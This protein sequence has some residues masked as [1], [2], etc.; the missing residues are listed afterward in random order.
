MELFSLFQFN[1]AQLMEAFL[2]RSDVDLHDDLAAD[3]SPLAAP[4]TP[5]PPPPSLRVLFQSL[6]TAMHHLRQCCANAALTIQLFSQLFH[7][8]NQWLFNR[9]VRQPHLGLL[10]REWGLRLG[11]RLARLKGWANRQGLEL[12]A[13]CHL[14]RICQACEL[15]Q[16]PKSELEALYNL[17]VDLVRLNSVQLRAIL[18]GY[19]PGINEPQIP[20]QW[21]DFV[22]SGASQV[23]DKLL[24]EE[25]V[26]GYLFFLFSDSILKV[27]W[28][29]L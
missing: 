2:D 5:R 20:G 19:L 24:E 1:L 12:A 16:A 27:T 28:N 29:Y 26:K 3:D 9:L 4:S 25:Q 21:I 22:A 17:S 13:D 7:F 8:V 18:S 6:S 23:A 15:L 14:L 11:R 10:Q